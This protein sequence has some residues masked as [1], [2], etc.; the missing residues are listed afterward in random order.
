MFWV[1]AVF[2]WTEE[3]NKLYGSFFFCFR[4][5]SPAQLLLHHRLGLVV[6]VSVSSVTFNV[7]KGAVNTLIV[8]FADSPNRLED[9]HP[10]S[11]QTLATAWSTVFPETNVRARLQYSTMV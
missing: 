7:I 5:I 9:N 10:E 8:C 6:A 2:L 11:T 3:K 4:K 1:S